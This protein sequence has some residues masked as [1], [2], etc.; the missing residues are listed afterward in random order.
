[1]ATNLERLRSF[2]FEPIETQEK[3]TNIFEI[4][5]FPRRETV[6]SNI[7]AFFFDPEGSHGLGNL[8]FSSLIDLLRSKIDSPELLDSVPKDENEVLVQTEVS[9]GSD[10]QNRIDLLLQTPNL[11]IGIENKVDATL[12]NDLD[13]YLKKVGTVALENKIYATCIVVL[14]AGAHIEY[15]EYRN[16]SFGTNLFDITYDE[17]FD[18][19]LRQ[20]G[21]KIFD[22]EKR[23]LDL[24]EQFIDNYS[25][26]R[27]NMKDDR[28][29]ELISQFT[30]QAGSLVKE[31]TA[32]EQ[33][34]ALYI[35]GC[36]EKITSLQEAFLMRTEGDEELGAK[37]ISSGIWDAGHYISAKNYETHINEESIYAVQNF[38]IFKEGNSKY[39]LVIE[40]FTPIDRILSAKEISENAFSA[41]YI[42]AHW[43]EGNAQWKAGNKIPGYFE[44]PLKGALLTDDNDKIIDALIAMYKE[45]IDHVTAL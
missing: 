4:A 7:F 23:S 26:K 8:F 11:V 16:L 29:N 34:K 25:E 14:H 45:I 1:M 40:F 42:K 22:I 44:I 33:S 10:T 12:Y 37:I 18:E 6:S 36:I 17:L 2:T 15:K 24:L 31:I 20:L 43:G 13:D 21:T 28:A 39:P 5:G 38:D 30:E 32:I 19:I 27:K 9:D 3:R 35:K 41:I